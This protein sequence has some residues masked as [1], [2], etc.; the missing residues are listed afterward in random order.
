MDLNNLERFRQFDPQRMGG[1]IDCLGDHLEAAWALGASLPVPGEFKRVER[2]VI[3]GMGGMA[4]GGDLLAA[5]LTWHCTTP[6]LVSRDPELPACA[7]GPQTLTVILSHSPMDES[8]SA[9][10]QASARGT[11]VL[12]IASGDSVIARAEEVGAV[13]WRFAFDG[14]D[15]AA[16]GWSFGLLLA[17]AD[18][19]GRAPGL[20]TDVAETVTVLRDRV[21]ILGME[22]PLVKNPAK[23]LA[24]QMMSRM[25]VIY[26][27][28]ILAPVARRWKTQLNENSKTWAAWEELPEM[29]YNAVAGI[30]FP[31]AI[32]VAVVFLTS[33]QYDT[34]RIA[35]RHEYTK[36]LYLQQ[37]IAPDT[38]KARG[39]SR[40]AQMLTSVQFGDYVSY[41]LAVAYGVDPTPT[42]SV[43]QLNEKLRS[44]Q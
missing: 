2:I 44:A 30:A 10:E 15:R 7:A 29:N 43:E 26:G 9:L 31:T 25:P 20:A 37:G 21:A 41:Y 1:H 22:S 17:L 33:P 3:M 14:E 18:R 34:P 38:I 23:R 42:P 12:V 5:L 19:L 24:G 35:R 6:I 8:L 4:I 11:A 36:E 27:A 39:K 28:G 32:R 13:V 40:L 16:L